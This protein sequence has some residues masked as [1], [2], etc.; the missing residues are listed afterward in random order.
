MD[1]TR[2]SAK[3][4]AAA[5]KTFE[6][7]TDEERG[8][9]KER[10]KELKGEARAKKGKADGERDVLAKIAEMPESDRTRPA[11]SSAS[12]HLR[13]SSR[14]GMRPS[15]STPRRTSTK[16]RCGRPPSR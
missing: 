16:A 6:G 15:A 2:K 14:I 13:R 10:A 4:A 5:G 12:S 8:A 3:S 11:R 7:F 9:M 1:D